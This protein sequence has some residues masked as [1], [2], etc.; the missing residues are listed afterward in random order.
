MSEREPPEEEAAETPGDAASREADSE[1]DTEPE[2]A[3]KPAR[4]WDSVR[5]L[6]F[7]VVFL[8]GVAVW[9]LIGPALA[10]Q[11]PSIWRVGGSADSGQA[12]VRLATLSDRI[13]ALERKLAA[14]DAGAANAA[15]ERKKLAGEA[16]E[17]AASTAALVKRLD[18]AEKPFDAV[19]IRLSALTDRIVTLE[20]GGT[21]G[22]DARVSAL[23]ARLKAMEADI[24]TAQGALSDGASAIKLTETATQSIRIELGALEGRVQALETAIK[25]NV[26]TSGRRHALVLAVGQLDQAVAAGRPYQAEIERIKIFAEEDGEI[27]GALKQLQESAESGVLTLAELKRRFSPLAGGIVRAGSAPRSEHWFDQASRKL[28]GLVTVRKTGDVAGTDPEAIV[29]RSEARLAANDLQGV[30][31]EL[32]TLQGAAA[33]VAGPWRTA[34]EARLIADRAMAQLQARAIALLGQS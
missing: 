28:M 32:A 18:A 26:G 22:G 12:E 17:R 23:G 14:V 24:A 9:P 10:P 33:E 16:K 2:A 5:I 25:D 27:D 21:D 6:V 8:A 19:D 30:V 20:A 13:E 4:Q 1:R 11:L 15:V 34:A 29:A 3:S 31:R 7:A